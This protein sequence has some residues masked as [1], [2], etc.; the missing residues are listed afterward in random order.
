MT[1]QEY[2]GKLLKIAELRLEVDKPRCGNCD[3]LW[4]GQ[5]RHHGAIPEDY[6]YQVNT[7]A[8]HFPKVPF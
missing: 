6:V 7:C 8:L 4:E 2:E 1:K 5:C 3:E